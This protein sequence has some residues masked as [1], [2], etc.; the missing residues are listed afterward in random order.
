MAR[1]K[2][3]TVYGYIGGRRV[4]ATNKRGH[5][6]PSVVERTNRFTVR[7]GGRYHPIVSSFAL[8][9]EQAHQLEE[10]SR[11]AYTPTSTLAALISSFIG[12]RE[13]LECAPNTIRSYQHAL[14]QFEQW[15]G[16]RRI[17]N[18]KDI[19]RAHIV[20]YIHYL[21]NKLVH[22]QG[23]KAG[24]QRA[25]ATIRANVQ[26]V[27]R[28]LKREMDVVIP[29]RDDDLPPLRRKMPRAY[30]PQEMATLLDHSTGDDKLAW[31]LLAMTGLRSG[32]LTALTYAD[33]GLDKDNPVIHIRPKTL[34]N[35]EPWKPKTVSSMRD[36]P[37]HPTL[38]DELR[39][40]GGQPDDF[41]I[42]AH[43]GG[44]EL[45]LLR[46]FQ[47]CASAAGIANPTLHA[48]RKVY[49]SRLVYKGTAITTVMGLLGHSSIT[50]TLKHYLEQYKATD[51]SLKR[52]V[53]NAFAD[54]VEPHT[55]QNAEQNTEQ[56][57]SER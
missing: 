12:S 23:Y 28:L 43:G 20:E 55:E 31:Q 36:I 7:F 49:T 52:D 39:A 10:Q 22:A 42:P 37:L 53:Q 57:E 14:A 38:A 17:A 26:L 24:R 15:C 3:A 27:L 47:A 21:E 51:E 50:P 32:E 54:L 30:T 56:K 4:R 6:I 48:L 34:P 45:N 46:R 41:V 35:G 18:P 40:R 25:A 16:Q 9:Q 1:G 8:A 44:R 29:L 33:L 2:T 19:T 13:R 5:A 11:A